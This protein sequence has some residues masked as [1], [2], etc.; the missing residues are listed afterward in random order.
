MS[1]MRTPLTK[2][3]VVD[4]QACLYEWLGIRQANGQGTTVSS[5]DITKSCLL[6]R[7]LIEGKPPLPT[8]PPRAY[9][10]PWY[11]V[12]EN[13]GADLPGGVFQSVEGPYDNIAWKAK[14]WPASNR[15]LSICQDLWHI[16]REIPGGYIVTHERLKGEWTLRHRTEEDPVVRGGTTRNHETGKYEE[17]YYGLADWVLIGPAQ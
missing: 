16:E 17:F 2:E 10:A 6:G 15:W 5:A 13:N 12:V 1:H 4:M 8:P 11:A 9:S 7:M 14:A 3:Q